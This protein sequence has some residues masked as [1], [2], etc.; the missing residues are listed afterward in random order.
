MDLAYI[1]SFVGSVLAVATPLLLVSSL[2]LLVQRS[3]VIN[4]GVEGA[5]LVGAFTAYAITLYTSNP[6]LGFLSAMAFGS[7]MAIL[8]AILAIY[9]WLDQIVVGVSMSV[10]SIGITSYLYRIIAGYGPPPKISTPI[11]GAPILKD[12]PIAGEILFQTPLTPIS[13][14]LPIAIWLIL[15]RS[16]FGAMVKAA[17][18]DPGRACKLGVEVTRIRFGLLAL[19]GLAS[20]AAGALLSIGYYSSF[21]E[22]MTAGRGYVAVALVILSS[23]SPSKLLLATLFFSLLEVSQLRLQATGIIEIPYQLALSIPYIFTLAILAISRGG[24]NAPRSL[25]YSEY[26]C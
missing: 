10:A 21:M 19:E 1:S 9:I 8:F 13:L 18:E 3:G 12:I 22:N 17:G 6:L 20:G 26:E 5:M 2:E 25:G 23:W 7:L 24:K 15:S 16:V 4:L 11:G 14:A